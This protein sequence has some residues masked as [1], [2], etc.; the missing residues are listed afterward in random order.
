MYNLNQTR[1]WKRM[2]WSKVSCRFHCEFIRN[3]ISA[4][5]TFAT[6]TVW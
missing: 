2:S 1:Y 4:L 5:E 6:G 3:S